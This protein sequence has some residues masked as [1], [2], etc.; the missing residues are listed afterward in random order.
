M[1]RRLFMAL[2][3]ALVM[4]MLIGP[5]VALGATGDR[6]SGFGTRAPSCDDGCPVIN[7]SFDARSG[8][9]GQNAS[10]WFAAE[11][12]D[13]SFT[14]KVTCLDESAGRWATI[15]GQITS[16]TGEAD[17]NTYTQDQE[18]LYFVV[19]VHG[20]GRR[21]HGSPAPDQMSLVGWDTEANF[22]NENNIALADI[23]ANPFQALNN[24]ETMFNLVAGDIRV[25][26]R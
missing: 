3:G 19:V 10:G 13:T 1:V 17:P 16:G 26:N 22:V 2:S 14:G 9:H 23:C 12:G 4:A 8:R 18:P 6:A 15:F 7:F 21:H 25:K 24:D 5:A 11:F 20:L